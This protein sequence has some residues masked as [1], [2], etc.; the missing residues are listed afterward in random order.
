MDL[1]VFFELPA[2]RSQLRADNSF[3]LRHAQR[4]KRD[5]LSNAVIEFRA[6]VGA[7]RVQYD[8]LAQDVVVAGYH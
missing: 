1:T 2:Q 3:Q 7:D 4:M 8:L 5:H 6:E